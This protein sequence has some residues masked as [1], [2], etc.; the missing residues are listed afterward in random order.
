MGLFS[1]KTAMEQVKEAEASIAALN[2]KLTAA[3]QAR[4]DAE[5]AAEDTKAHADAL[6]AKYDALAGELE[7]S[8]AALNQRNEEFEAEVGKQVA[9]QLAAAGHEPLTI[10]GEDTPKSKPEATANLSGL[11]KTIA[12]FKAKQK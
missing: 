12:A 7:A 9:A 1:G 10:K 5:R 11:E 8:Q 4:S 2:E 3:E 6:Q